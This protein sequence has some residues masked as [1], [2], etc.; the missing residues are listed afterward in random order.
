[1]GFKS[2]LE[3]WNVWQKSAEES[4]EAIRGQSIVGCDQRFGRSIQK[5]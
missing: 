4:F 5:L 1:M 3:N 2:P